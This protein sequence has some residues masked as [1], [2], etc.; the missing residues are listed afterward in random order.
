MSKETAKKAQTIKKSSTPWWMWVIVVGLGLALVGGLQYWRFSRAM[1]ARRAAM[2][3]QRAKLVDFWKAEGLS[4]EEINQKLKTDRSQNLQRTGQ[5]NLA[6]MMFRMM[7]GGFRIRQGGT[8]N[9]GGSEQ[10]QR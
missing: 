3:A 4:D 8:G 2:Q 6:G 1:Y 10:F 7:G 9:V 5:Q